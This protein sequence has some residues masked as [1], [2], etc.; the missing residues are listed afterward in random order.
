MHVTQEIDGRILLTVSDSCENRPIV[1]ENLILIVLEELT[2]A[3][4]KNQFI[5][6]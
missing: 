4:L 3:V 5:A 1:V 6:N 2:E